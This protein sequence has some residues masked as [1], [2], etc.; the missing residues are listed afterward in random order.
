[1]SLSLLLALSLCAFVH[2]SDSFSVCG[3]GQHSSPL[4]ETPQ[5]S[6]V[7]LDQACSTHE[8]H[9]LL[10]RSVST[11]VSLCCSVSLYVFVICFWYFRFS[12]N[13]VQ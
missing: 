6:W 5:A 13:F 9:T 1:M 7:G 3:V 12:F 11:S 8:V 2:L 4:Q 10:S